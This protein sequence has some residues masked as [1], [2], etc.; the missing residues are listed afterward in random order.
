MTILQFG[1]DIW[2][3]LNV[4]FLED[5]H[6]VKKLRYVMK[7]KTSKWEH[8]NTGIPYHAYEPGSILQNVITLGEVQAR[9]TTGCPKKKLKLNRTRF[10]A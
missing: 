2:I 7:Y 1:Q 9:V 8:S 10:S 6:H 4:Q 3:W 5:H